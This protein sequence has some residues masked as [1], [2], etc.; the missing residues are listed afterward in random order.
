MPAP[1]QEAG[2]DNW[3]RVDSRVCAHFADGWQLRPIW[4]Q[5]PAL[6]QR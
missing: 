2:G 4:P 3:G 5:P 6:M 1:Q